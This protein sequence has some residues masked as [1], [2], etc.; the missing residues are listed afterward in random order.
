MT[1][2]DLTRDQ[3]IEL[4]QAFLCDHYNDVSWLDLA[5]A[6]ERI[7]DTTIFFS[8][9]EQPHKSTDRANLTSD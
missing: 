3:L 8:P 1:V 4:K 5:C 7:S 2:K 9:D 6:D